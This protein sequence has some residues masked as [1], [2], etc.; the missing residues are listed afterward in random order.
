MTDKRYNPTGITAQARQ[1][2]LLKREASDLEAITAAQAK[3]D[4]KMARLAAAV[5]NKVVP[6]HG[7]APEFSGAEERRLRK[8]VK[9]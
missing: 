7:A 8:R 6:T 4:R 1:H 2:P 9:K 3:R 5:T